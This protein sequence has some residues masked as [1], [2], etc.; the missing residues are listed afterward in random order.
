MTFSDGTLSRWAF[1]NVRQRAWLLFHVKVTY[2]KFT[3]RYGCGCTSIQSILSLALYHCLSSRHSLLHRTSR[4][5]VLTLY[6]AIIYWFFRVTK[7]QY[8]PIG[9][10]D[11]F[12]L[13]CLLF[14]RFVL[15][16]RVC[17]GI[18][19]VDVI[20]SDRLKTALDVKYGMTIFFCTQ[21]SFP[22]HL[23]SRE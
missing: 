4:E 5:F 6:V 19:A 13:L 14:S 16:F 22:M 15:F 11:T 8:Y 17:L 3:Y 9:I 23:R 2:L 20:T 21:S 18:T 10:N 1:L 7:L 12:K